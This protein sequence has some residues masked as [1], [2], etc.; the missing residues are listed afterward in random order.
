MAT[1]I[2][3]DNQVTNRELSRWL[4]E[5]NGEV[6]IDWPFGDKPDVVCTSHSYIR[7]EENDFVYHRYRIRKWCDVD[8]RRISRS[9]MEL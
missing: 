8:W 5:G 7:N 4:A 9:Y 2:I 1:V 3:Q 6:R